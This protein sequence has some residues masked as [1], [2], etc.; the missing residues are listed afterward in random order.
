MKLF[1]RIKIEEVLGMNSGWKFM[2]P[3]K[4]YNYLIK[5][6]TVKLLIDLN[7]SSN[8]DNVSVSGTENTI[9]QI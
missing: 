1:K 5:I 8:S 3:I 4:Q 6:C 7:F 2:I 9:I